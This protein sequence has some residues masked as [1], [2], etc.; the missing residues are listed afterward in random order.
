VVLHTNPGGQLRQADAPSTGLNV[1]AAHGMAAEAPSAYIPAGAAVQADAAVTLE[2]VPG[3][4]GTEAV[5]P[6][7][8][9]YV[10]NDAA[11]HT[12]SPAVAEKVPLLHGSDVVPL[13]LYVP[14]EAALQLEEAMEA[15]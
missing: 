10:P 4:H 8:A 1:P 2:K 15:A 3:G 6:T 14:A 7:T 9:T 12:A 13:L 11:V 5:E